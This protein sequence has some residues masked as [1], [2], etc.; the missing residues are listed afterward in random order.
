MVGVV[1]KL[2][3]KEHAKIDLLYIYELSIRYL[4]SRAKEAQDGLCQRSSH[5][6]CCVIQ[7]YQSASQFL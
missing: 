3:S 1:K 2:G 4:L 7:F 5:F 6:Q